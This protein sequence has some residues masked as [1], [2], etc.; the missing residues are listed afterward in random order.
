MENNV[1]KKAVKEISKYVS[2]EICR[3]VKNQL[4]K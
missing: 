1:D 4:M 3:Q 2:K